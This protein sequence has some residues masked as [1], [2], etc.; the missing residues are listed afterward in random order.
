M[1][2]RQIWI[3]VVTVAGIWI[4]IDRQWMSLSH[5]R[6]LLWEVGT[7]QKITINYHT[8]APLSEIYET[9]NSYGRSQQPAD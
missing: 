1:G 3:T 9:N 2:V 5:H 4:R 7:N 6:P 8:V